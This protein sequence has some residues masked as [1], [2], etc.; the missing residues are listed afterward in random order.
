LYRHRSE[1]VFGNLMD[2][3]IKGAKLRKSLPI[4]TGA[5]LD[6]RCRRKGAL[7]LA[8]ALPIYSP[9]HWY[10]GQSGCRLSVSGRRMA[11]T[12]SVDM[13]CSWRV[14]TRSMF[15]VFHPLYC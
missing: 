3:K 1:S 7:N 15:L 11:N 6:P 9:S 5:I 10:R 4:V 8:S 12:N 14:W 2:R 13:V